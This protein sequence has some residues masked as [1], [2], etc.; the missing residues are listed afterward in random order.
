MFNSLNNIRGLI[1]EN[2]WNQGKWYQIVW[3]VTVFFNKSE[4]NTIALEEE[5]EMVENFIAISKFNWKIDCNL[6]QK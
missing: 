4:I 3:D 5:I 6:F 2:L 1:L